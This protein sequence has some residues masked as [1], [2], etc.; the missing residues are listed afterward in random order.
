MELNFHVTQ[1]PSEILL[2]G[3]FVVVDYGLRLISSYKDKGHNTH[4]LKS[5]NVRYHYF[6]LGIQQRLQDGH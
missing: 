2:H 4:D 6:L 5:S 3:Y 1:F